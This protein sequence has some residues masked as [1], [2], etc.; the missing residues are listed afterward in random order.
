[1]S[2][3]K[4][5]EID[6][7]VEFLEDE[8]FSGEASVDKKI[9]KLRDK[10]N[11]CE[12]EKKQNLEGWQRS[13]ADLINFKKEVEEQKKF[14]MQLGHE[15]VISDLLP[16]IDAFYSAMK[17]KESWE[18]V[19]SNW[20]TG[21]EYI[22]NQLLKTIEEYDGSLIIPQSGDDL[23]DAVHDVSGDDSDDNDPKVA[24]VIRPGLKINGKVIRTALVK[25]Q[26]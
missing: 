11:A 22:H 24:D 2:K 9:K 23:D 17:N 8:D 19:D 16:V 6:D 20:R 15:S 1:M 10:L 3:N 13:K 21:V 26:A 7:S 14:Y 4:N 12:D 18:S 25:L 5:Q